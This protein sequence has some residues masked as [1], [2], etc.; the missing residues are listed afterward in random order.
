M[1][2]GGA[3][4]RVVV[5]GFGRF[6]RATQGCIPDRSEKL[7]ASV[8]TFLGPQPAPVT[9]YDFDVDQRH[10]V[11][12]EAS[13]RGNAGPDDPPGGVV[14]SSEPAMPWI[15]NPFL[16]STAQSAG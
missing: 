13:R 3:T 16:G 6:N 1:P 2:G 15:Q 10:I 11:R 14:E 9:A 12:E 5:G 4:R 8:S 7:S